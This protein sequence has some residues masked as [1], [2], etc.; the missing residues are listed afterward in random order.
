M[1]RVEDVDLRPPPQLQN[2]S[3]VYVPRYKDLPTAV[4]LTRARDGRDTNYIIILVH[5]L[6]NRDVI[7]TSR[8]N[9]R[10]PKN[11]VSERSV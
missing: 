8:N 10:V 7:F 4:D 5:D 11:D 2:R 9:Q 1:L 3:R 6:Q